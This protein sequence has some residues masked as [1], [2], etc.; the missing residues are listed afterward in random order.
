MVCFK[1]LTGLCGA[2]PPLEK[3]ISSGHT[4]RRKG[5]KAARPAEPDTPASQQGSG[6]ADKVSSIPPTPPIQP[7]SEETGKTS[8]PN[9]S[10]DEPQAPEGM[11]KG[12]RRERSSTFEKLTCFYGAYP[13]LEK[14]TSPE[15]TGQHKSTQPTEADGAS[16]TTP[17]E[18]MQPALGTGKTASTPPPADPPMEIDHPARAARAPA[19]DGEQTRQGIQVDSTRSDRDAEGSFPRAAMQLAQPDVDSEDDI[20]WPGNTRFDII[21]ALDEIDAAFSSKES[22]DPDQNVPDIHNASSS[23]AKSPTT[24]TGAV[25]VTNNDIDPE[26][27]LP[28][29]GG[30]TQFDI[31]SALDEIDA[32]FS[33]KESYDPDQ[34]VPD[35]HNES[36]SKAKSSTTATGAVPVTNN[37]IDPEFYLPNMGGDSTRSDREA[38]GS[39]LRAAMQPAK[40]DVDSEDD[41]YWPGNTPFDIT[42]A[43]DEIDAAFS[44]KESY[45]PDQNVPDIHNASSSKAK[46]PTTAT[47]A[48]RVANNDVDP[49]IHL[50]NMGDQS[51]KRLLSS[52]PAP[53]RHSK[54]PRRGQLPSGG[55]DNDGEEN[56][57]TSRINF[58]QQLVSMSQNKISL[59]YGRGTRRN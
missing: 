32:A 36:S 13:S 53:Q 27:Y 56:P 14:A 20:Y 42:S 8:S 45:D 44:S 18:V 23:K 58:K 57:S 6:E 26:F 52:P 51:N 38:E 33:N 15:Q 34:N 41:I 19:S 5:K 54:A 48:V 11:G 10:N 39:F 1:R 3:A 21:S 25:P 40:P 9:D 50:P 47:G 30:N 31:I 12:K 29:M 43:L 24:A 55:D 59:K 37:D 16:S 7:A 22:Y 4:G 28:N 2:H 49:E 17:G 35:I 46:S